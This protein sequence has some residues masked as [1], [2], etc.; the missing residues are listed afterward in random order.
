MIDICHGYD[1]AHSGCVLID[2]SDVARLWVTG[3]DRL[4]L[5]HRMSTN[6]LMN[7]QQNEGRA[8]VL[9][10]AV[11]RIVDVL[12]T[13]HLGKQVLLLGSPG[14]A[15]EVRDWL[16]RYI[17]YQDEV[18]IS[19]ATGELG[20]FGLYGAGADALV[21]TMAVGAKQLSLHHVIN[22]DGA[23]IVRAHN[24]AGGGYEVIAKPSVIEK[25]A[26]DAQSLGA[27]QASEELYDLLRIEA[28]LPGAGR[29][30]SDA[31][32]PLEVGLSDAVSFDKGCYIGQEIIARMESR[33]KLAKTLIG[34]RSDS[35]LPSGA[36]L[37]SRDGGRRGIITSS[38]HSPRLGWIGIGLIKPD[39]AEPGALLAV[40]RNGDSLP[41]TVTTLPFGN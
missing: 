40:E 2:R 5:L 24:L 8:T 32:I 15:I 16:A 10:T 31:Y 29:E 6:D 13:L 30:I 12:V 14:K 4:D 19:D 1:A 22:T 18:V 23:W 20:Q 35:E 25:L 37:R 17:F 27:V 36:T 33:G 3:R 38:V 7:M 28:G 41:V 39:M 11:G 9:T 34:L 21:E 26:I